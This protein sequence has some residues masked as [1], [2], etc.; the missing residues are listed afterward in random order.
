MVVIGLGGNTSGTL[1]AFKG[2]R[3]FLGLLLEDISCSSLYRTSPQI[4]LDQE[5]FWNSAVSG[6][7]PGS[8]EALLEKLLMWEAGAGRHRDPKRPKGPRIID[9]D[10]L[11][12]GKEVRSSARLTLPHPGL[13]NRRF[14]LEPLI[15][16]NPKAVDPRTGI[17]WIDL[18]HTLPGQGVD[19]MDRTW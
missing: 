2:A 17:L 4:D 11:V 7:W 14:A 3:N 15:E 18:L 9:L 19:R 6:R 8:A 13:D 10:L 16:V 12:F 5:P 1:A